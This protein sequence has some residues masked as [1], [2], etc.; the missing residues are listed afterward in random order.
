MKVLATLLT[1]E[2]KHW[3]MKSLHV[4]IF[5]KNSDIYSS[6]IHICFYHIKYFCLLFKFVDIR[7]TSIFGGHV[8]IKQDQDRVSSSTS[9]RCLQ[10]PDLKM[11][12]PQ[13]PRR[14]V[15]Y[16]LISLK[17]AENIDN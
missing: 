5:T 10:M 12:G 1:I 16:F 13:R 11:S 14:P 8:F 17:E 4:F 3:L 15:I 7:I 2:D 9:A 6:Y